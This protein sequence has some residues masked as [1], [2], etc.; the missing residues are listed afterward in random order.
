MQSKKTASALLPVI[1]CLFLF[2]A[3]IGCPPSEEQGIGDSPRSRAEV[4]S[5]HENHAQAVRTWQLHMRV[6]EDAVEGQP[7]VAEDLMQAGLFFRELTG[8]EI[9]GEG[10][11][12][13]WLATPET[14]ED[15]F[16]L[17]DWFLEH[18]DDLRWDSK[19]EVVFLAGEGTD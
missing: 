3:P 18:R 6:L 10:S 4:S 11:Y 1:A 13:G 16:S 17:K 19:E 7:H 14:R 8:I 5:Y 2:S 15:L 12:V 9:R